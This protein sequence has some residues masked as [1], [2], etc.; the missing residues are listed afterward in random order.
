MAISISAGSVHLESGSVTS[1][2]AD[3]PMRPRTPWPASRPS[4]S[5]VRPTCCLAASARS[6]AGAGGFTTGRRV[7]P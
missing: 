4:P 1:T 7:C 3:E 5:C 2:P 6:A